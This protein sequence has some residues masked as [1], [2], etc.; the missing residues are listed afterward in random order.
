MIRNTIYFCKKCGNRVDGESGVCTGCGKKY[1]VLKLPSLR[2]AMV[3]ALIMLLIL[4]NAALVLVSLNIKE[5][6]NRQTELVIE[7]TLQ[8]EEQNK[9]ILELEAENE[10]DGKVVEYYLEHGVFI[11]KSGEDAYYHAY[12]CKLLFSA[13]EY[14]RSLHADIAQIT[15]LSEAIRLGYHPCPQ[16]CR[17]N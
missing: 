2:S 9:R 11:I 13:S 17:K 4:S 10:T 8:L 7:K 1:F 12:D 6:T 14:K 5:E 15:E 16:C 3:F